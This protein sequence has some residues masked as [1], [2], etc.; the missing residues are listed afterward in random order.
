MSEANQTSA[1][2]MHEALMAYLYKEATGDEARRF[3][4]HLGECAACKQEIADFGRV[5]Q[6]LQQWQVVDLP[7][8]RVVADPQ[9]QKRSF[10]AVLKELLTVMPVW[11]KAASV[12]AMALIVMAVTGTSVNIGRDGFAINTRLIGSRQPVAGPAAANVSRAEYV[13]AEQL[14]QLR[15]NLTA[16]VAQ[17]VADSERQQK[18]ALKAELVSLQNDLQSMR[19]ADL[20]KIVARV[21]EHQ[22]RL[23]T[24]ERDLDRR[25]GTDLTDL[26]FSEVLSKPQ[27]PTGST[28]GGH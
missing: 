1:C 5:R 23:Q 22:S 4:A 21:Q 20:A 6:Q 16:L 17:K 25:E 26:L 28:P 27:P 18:D 8:V 9:P 7:I 15:A 13:S 19:S 11:A 3:E 24:I 14:E 12:G 2:G 10:L